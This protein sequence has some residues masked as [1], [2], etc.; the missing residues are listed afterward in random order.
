MTRMITPRQPRRLT[1]TRIG[2]LCWI[3][4]AALFLLANAVAQF[5]WTTP[6][7]LRDNN[8]SDLGNVYCRNSGADNPP[9]RYICS[10]DH[11]LFNTSVIVATVLVIV[12]VLL[13]SRW[14]GRG[15]A[16]MAA[17]VLIV[18]GAGGYVLAGV[19][20]ADV[21]LDL[22]VLGAALIMLG[23]NVGLLVAGLAFRRGA[24]ARLRTPTVVISVVAFVAALMHFSGH[25][26][27]LGMGGTERVSVYALEVWLVLVAVHILQR[28]A[29]PRS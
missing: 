1:A 28:R 9:D 27:G 24:L 5:A 16:S 14:W 20:P 25:Y 22:H 19:W 29:E 2:A 17:R 15:V 18:A 6:Y 3:I 21:N 7:S 13:T 23:G 10:P 11:A 4:S 12:G 8:I 26:A